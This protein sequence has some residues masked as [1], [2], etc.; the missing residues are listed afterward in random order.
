MVVIT[1]VPLYYSTSKGISAMS[2][3]ML[4]TQRHFRSKHQGNCFDGVNIEIMEKGFG[5]K[6][7]EHT[8][9]NWFKN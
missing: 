5:T 7:H 1:N 8:F 9:W 2:W 3:K 6:K 4:K